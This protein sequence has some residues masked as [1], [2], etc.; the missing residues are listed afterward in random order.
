M[1]FCI[2]LV[3]ISPI[4]AQKASM[5]V[6]LLDSSFASHSDF[7]FEIEVKNDSFPTYWIQDTAL[8]RAR[9][10]YPPSDLLYVILEKKVG[11]KYRSYERLKQHLGDNFLMDSCVRYCCNC[12]YIGKGQTIRLRM[13]LLSNYILEK[14]Q[15]KMEVTLGPPL[16]SCNNC[17]QIKLGEIFTDFYFKIP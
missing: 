10:G 17:D 7:I 16:E 2:I 3:I 6:K 4:S 11:G 8:L 12:I 14:G 1:S 5:H 13:P 9:F 15:Y